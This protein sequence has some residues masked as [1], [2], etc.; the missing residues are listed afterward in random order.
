MMRRASALCAA[1]ILALA[2]VACSRSDEKG[3]AEQT[4]KAIDDTMRESAQKMNEAGQK[5][6]EAMQKAGQALEDAAK[7]AQQT[8]KP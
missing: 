8:P 4:G 1:C 7:R 3:P 5:M 2:A 6:G